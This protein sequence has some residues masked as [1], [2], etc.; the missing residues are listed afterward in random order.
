MKL[1][2]K[3]QC[4][5]LIAALSDTMNMTF[6]YSYHTRQYED[7]ADYDHAVSV[8]P[9]QLGPVKANLFYDPSIGN[10]G[11]GEKTFSSDRAVDRSTNDSE[12][13]QTELKVYF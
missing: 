1:Y 9:F 12:W 7:Y 4:L 3:T 13:E 5:K 2:C 6:T 8:V 10:M 11:R